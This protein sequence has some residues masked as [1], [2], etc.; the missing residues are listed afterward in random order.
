MPWR[1]LSS[2]LPLWWRFIITFFDRSRYTGQWEIRAK[3]EEQ[4]GG[5]KTN[6]RWLPFFYS[7]FFGWSVANDDGAT[8]YAMSSGVTNDPG[9]RRMRELKSFC[10]CVCA[11][12]MLPL[13]G[14]LMESSHSE[15][16]HGIIKGI[17]CG[18][19]STRLLID[20]DPGQLLDRL[21]L[22]VACS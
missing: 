1:F 20:L 6:A 8:S 10:V 17:Y 11:R 2:R 18:H 22:R 16:T 15:C 7:F 12:E 19:R 14:W 5:R 21:P 4:K 9:R 3:K 13:A